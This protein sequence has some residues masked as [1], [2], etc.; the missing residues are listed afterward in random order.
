MA[1]NSSTGDAAGL[2]RRASQ[3]PSRLA[4]AATVAGQISQ[5]ITGL[6]RRGQRDQ[7]AARAAARR[8]NAAPTVAPC[9]HDEEPDPVS[10]PARLG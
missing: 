7:P 5:A 10:D 1:R 8:T 3:T 2:S 6:S 9:S 4:R